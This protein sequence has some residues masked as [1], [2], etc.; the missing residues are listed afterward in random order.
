MVDP[1][2][3]GTLNVLRSCKKS[4]TVKRVV[5]TSSSSTIRIRNDIEPEQMLDEK[6]WTSLD[7]CYQFKVN[8]ET[9]MPNLNQS[10]FALHTCTLSKHIKFATQISL[11][12]ESRHS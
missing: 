3:N 12:I 7:I 1:A 9:F 6:S 10:I 5:V 11:K 4:N 8:V 2:V